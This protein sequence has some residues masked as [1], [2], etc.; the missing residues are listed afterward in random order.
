MGAKLFVN[1]AIKMWSLYLVETKSSCLPY[2]LNRWWTYH[3]VMKKINWK[4]PLNWLYVG[5]WKK[6]Y[7]SA[8]IK[9]RWTRLRIENFESI[10]IWTRT[11][12]WCLNRHI[13][14]K[15]IRDFWNM[16]FFSK[17]SNNQFSLTVYRHFQNSDT[18]IRFQPLLVSNMTTSSG[19]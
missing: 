13:N 2:W 14:C 12:L 3:W 7:W 1:S 6:N 17:T 10:Y 5:L 8:K 16:F 9:K 15:I 11:F 4:N 18:L 19:S